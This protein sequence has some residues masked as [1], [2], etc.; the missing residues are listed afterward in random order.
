MT[1]F[2]SLGVPRPLVSVLAES[3]ITEAFPIQA[4]TLPHS[5]AGADVLGR[6]RTG[7]GK[8]IAFALPMVARLAAERGRPTPGQPRGL[9]L[10]PTREL[11][12][13][14][15]QTIT[16]LAKAMGLY[17]TT[18]YGGVAQRVQER[19]LERGVDIV[20]ACPGRL[21][22]LMGQGV[23][24]LSQVEITVVDEADQMADMGF[25]PGVT[26]ILEATP[27]WGQRLLFSATLDG[28]IDSLVRRFLPQAVRHELD[29]SSVPADTMVHRVF[30]LV[31]QEDKTAMVEMLASG[32]G[33]RILF[34]R[35]KH[36]AMRLAAALTKA[37]IPAVDL[38]G[39]LGQ[40]ARSRNLKAFGTEF[41]EGGVRVLVATD[42]AA[43]GVHVDGVELV[44][45]VDPP[46]EHKAYLHRA[47][48]TARAGAEGT[49]VTLALG[50]QRRDL[51]RVLRTAGIEVTPENVRA[52]D[53]VVVALVG[54]QAPRGER[55]VPPRAGR[56]GRGADAGGR[57]AGHAGGAG[58]GPRS[59]GKHHDG[60]RGGA[61][62][63]ESHRGES[64]RGESHRGESHRPAQGYVE[65]HTHG[66]A[67]AAPRRGA[68]ARGGRSERR[69][70]PLGEYRPQTR[71]GYRG[72]G[73]RS[74]GGRGAG[75][76]GDAPRYDRDRSE[77]F[78]SER[79]QGERRDAYRGERAQGQRRDAYRGDTPSFDRDRGEGFRTERAHGER[80]RYQARGEFRDDRRGVSPRED[81]FGGESRGTR[82]E[83]RG[84]RNGGREGFRE[85]GFRGNGFRGEG[86]RGEARGQFRDDRRGANARTD[87]FRGDG[88]RED[89]FREDG[90]REDGSRGER[91]PQRDDRDVSARGS[92][93]SAG[94]GER[95]ADRAGR[96]A[97][98]AGRTQDRPGRSFGR[99]E[100]RPE[101]AT[102]GGR[103]SYSE[104][105][106]SSRGASSRG[107]SSRGARAQA[108]TRKPRAAKQRRGF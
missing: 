81:R 86:S 104:N 106:G 40:G 28:D 52:M 22:D 103:R 66:D 67:V 10:A 94:S 108:G 82:G 45:H 96:S 58:R 98:R 78:R 59:G 30:H 77:G 72:E 31:S 79:A 65:G 48:R 57:G 38:H 101:R 2:A 37:G 68:D 89:G 50:P 105:G 92:Y 83:Y 97:G 47:G 12:E 100:R 76:R 23:V 9:V 69:F 61:Y 63:G 18:I 26:R 32:M 49:V 74:E 13:Q 107:A 41:A 1:S 25:L 11:A 27:E 14:I 90:F 29:E 15:A 53:D 91:R 24:K 20:V 4:E 39:N 62:R 54:E 35:T 44:V 19:A 33:R 21:E 56:R 64:Y 93:G 80:P 71:E 88:Y 51:A 87:R 73:G 75:F 17:V 36:H 55:I 7:S 60:M 16:P 70:E 5:L 8:T 102:E 6:G 3:G 99:D 34:T 84:A 95:S 43:R 42:V 85:D 46:A